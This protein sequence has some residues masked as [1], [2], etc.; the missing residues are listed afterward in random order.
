MAFCCVTDGDM[1]EIKNEALERLRPYLCEKLVAERHLDYLRSQRVLTRDDAEDICCRGGNAKKTVRMLDYLSE[2]PRG[3]DCL[4]ESFCRV[5][6]KDFVI[7]KITSEVETV[8]E[9]RAVLLEAAA[10][11]SLVCTCGKGGLFVSFQSNSEGMCSC[12]STSSQ[13]SFTNSKD[14]HGQSEAAFSWSAL[15]EGMNVSTAPLLPK[16]GE[17]GGPL[18][19]TEDIEPGTFWSESTDQFHTLRSYSTHSQ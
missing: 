11:S 4:V 9:R 2:N 6:T 3:L 10:T 12:E 1:E 13:A 5:R 18:V 15:H 8:K 14:T 19:P 17:Q 7:V 16:P